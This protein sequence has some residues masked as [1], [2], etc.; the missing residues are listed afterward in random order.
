MCGKD[1][2]E[3]FE[4][5]KKASGAYGIKVDEPLWVEI[6]SKT[7]SDMIAEVK[8]KLTKNDQ[9]IVALYPPAA[10]KGW[11]SAL[12]EACSK[13]LGVPVQCV[14][15]KTITKGLSAVSKILIQMSAKIGLEP[16][17]MRPIEGLPEK[18][19]IVGADVF[20]STK[21]GKKSAV[22]FVS[23]TNPQFSK[24]YS[25][26]TYQKTGQELM[27][28]IGTLMKD[29]VMVYL[30]RNKYLPEY[31]IFY[32][33]GV[34]E[35]QRELIM[36]FET[37]AILTELYTLG[38]NE[39]RPK[40]AELIVT[41]RVDDRFFTKDQKGNYQNPPAGTIVHQDCVSN[42]FDFFNVAQY[43]TQGTCTPTNYYC[44]YD[45]TGLPQDVFWNLSYSQ[46]Y[47]YVNWMGGIRVPA[48]VQYAHKY[49]YLAG[50][51]IK[52]DVMKDLDLSL[53][54]L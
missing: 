1:A 53:F 24:Y 18:T 26:V 17:I 37:Q 30:K 44:V 4:M 43:V 20:H 6:K 12:K 32:R 33:D 50:Q 41:K 35:N 48:V 2:D 51:T 7:Q 49:A 15:N 52:G 40:F 25:K 31:I 45:D 14:I 34:A 39:Y 11:Y 54:Y 5:M 28:G 27:K 8:R 46:C 10:K 29:A 13:E 42:N 19:M 47:N 38:N 23:T 36:E 9:I 22:G 16:W 3:L 21:D